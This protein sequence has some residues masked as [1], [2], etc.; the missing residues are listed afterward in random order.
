MEYVNIGRVRPIY[1][2]EHNPELNYEALDVVR[3]KDGFT[4][5]MA[6]KAVPAGKALTDEEYWGLL[7]KVKSDVVQY[8]SAQTLTGEQ[9]DQ[10]RANIGAASD[11]DVIEIKDEIE[12]HGI[13]VE[14]GMLCVITEG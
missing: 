14:N 8:G 11:M 5:Y 4:S 6:K 7:N 10:A 1:K 3:S 12:S 13:V 9:Q 2:G